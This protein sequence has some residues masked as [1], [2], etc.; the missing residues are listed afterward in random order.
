VR[1]HLAEQLKAH[2]VDRLAPGFW[3]QYHPKTLREKLPKFSVWCWQPE[4]KR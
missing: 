2:G 3:K 4:R 1:D